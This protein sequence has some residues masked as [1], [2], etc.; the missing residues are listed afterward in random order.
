MVVPTTQ[1]E[2]EWMQSR[3]SNSN[4]NSLTYVNL[5]YWLAFLSVLTSKIDQKPIKFLMNL[6]NQRS[7]GLN[8]QES[9]VNH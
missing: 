8:E 9:K 1:D 4:H 7:R 6:C 2:V 3:E 5:G